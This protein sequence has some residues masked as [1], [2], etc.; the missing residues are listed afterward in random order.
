MSEVKNNGRGVNDEREED[1]AKVSTFLVFLVTSHVSHLTSFFSR[2]TS[3]IYS[4]YSITNAL[5]RL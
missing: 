4:K 5:A 3:H 1:D 2:L